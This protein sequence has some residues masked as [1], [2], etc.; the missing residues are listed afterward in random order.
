MPWYRNEGKILT[1][2]TPEDFTKG[3]TEGTFI[4]PNH[5]GYCAFLFYSALRKTEA[6]KL[7]KMDFEVAKKN[8]LVRAE[9]PQIVKRKVHHE[10]GTV[11]KEATGK[12]AYGRLKHGKKTPALIIPR[13]A[14]Y[15]NEI[16]ESIEHAQTQESLVWPYSAMT[17]YRIVHRAGFKYP[18]LFR[19]SRITNF[20]LPSPGHP[21][22]WTIAQVKSWTGLT[23]TALEFYVGQTD[24]Q[25]MGESLGDVQ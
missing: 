4:Q 13:N 8:I 3:M 23:L 24:V 6:L 16:I 25:K 19:L 17:G 18:H 12:I 1:P 10:D 22:G 7:R 20:F 2:L 11:T 5:R 21:D 9:F 14:P 15:V